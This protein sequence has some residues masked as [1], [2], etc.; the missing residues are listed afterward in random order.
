MNLA[1][2]FDE[3]GA[4]DYPFS[5]KDYKFAYRELVQK[6]NEN[7]INTVIA[8]GFDTYMGTGKF[9][10]G[11]VFDDEGELQEVDAFEVDLVLDRGA[12]DTFKATD[13]KAVNNRE[14]NELCADKTKTYELFSDLCAYSAAVNDRA[15]FLRELETIDG[16]KV[17]IKPLSGFGGRGVQILDKQ[18]ARQQAGTLEY[19]QLMQKYIDTTGGIRGVVDGPHDLRIVVFSGNPVLA[20][21]RQ[22]AEGSLIANVALGGTLTYKDLS[23]IPESAMELVKTIDQRLED[24]GTRAYSID[25][26]FEGENVFLIELNSRPGL[27]SSNKGKEAVLFQ[28][29]L[30]KTLLTA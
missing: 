9:S 25:M 8:R 1:I 27:N 26:A 2:Y 22:P 14:F 11:W 3:P 18:D 13:V 5:Q 24:Y 7:G 12:E 4:E 16:D 28:D 29:E 23:S 21:V 17:V 30:V 6:L 20:M 15:S 19:P 10:K